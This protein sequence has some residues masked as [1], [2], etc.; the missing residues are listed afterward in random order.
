MSREALRFLV[1]AALVILLVA[2]GYA[3]YRVILV[4]PH[5]TLVNRGR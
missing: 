3:A 5:A 4:Q 1:A 2:G